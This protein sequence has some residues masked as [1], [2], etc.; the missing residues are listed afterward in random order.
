MYNSLLPLN[1]KCIFENVHLLV[2]KMYN[3]TMKIVNM[4]FSH[5]L[6]RTK[7]YIRHK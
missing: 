1:E 6:L 5:L 2:V 3:G 4:K 7:K